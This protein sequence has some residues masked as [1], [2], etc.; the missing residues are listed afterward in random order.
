VGT[1]LSGC[2]EATPAEPAPLNQWLAIKLADKTIEIQIAHQESEM[3]KGLMYRTSLDEDRGMLFYYY[4]PKRMSF[5]MRNT[6]I[7]LDI[8][9]FTADGILREVYPMYPMDEKSVPSRGNEMLMALEMNQGWFA[10]NSIKA[11]NAFDLEILR[12]ALEYRGV[13]KQ[14][15]PF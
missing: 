1:L 2:G 10:K 5:W 4:P 6:K 7:P 12:K 9:Y 11:G 14:T 15:I 3:A 8:A 13:A